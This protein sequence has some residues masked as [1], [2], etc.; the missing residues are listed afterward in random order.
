VEIIWSTRSLVRLEEIAEF[1]SQD[2]PRRAFEFIEKLR[3]SINRLIDFPLSGPV[4]LENPAYRQL[5]F[6]GY[7]VIYHVAPKRIEIF[8]IVSPGLLLSS[9]KVLRKKSKK[10]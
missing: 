9:A 7:R 10:K 2:S 3:A 5:V 8:T 4:A 6:D 1:I